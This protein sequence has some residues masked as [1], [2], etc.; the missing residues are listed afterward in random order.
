MLAGCA[1]LLHLCRC[2]LRCCDD[3]RLC[4]LQRRPVL[5][6]A[7]GSTRGTKTGWITVHVRPLCMWSLDQCALRANDHHPPHT[8]HHTT[9]TPVGGRAREH[10]RHATQHSAGILQVLGGQPRHADGLQSTLKLQP[11]LL[12]ATRGRCVRQP[13]RGCVVGCCL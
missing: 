11:L 7:R 6:T 8:T 12:Y 1:R 10:K 2:C 5:H 13:T 9:H 3:S 4:L